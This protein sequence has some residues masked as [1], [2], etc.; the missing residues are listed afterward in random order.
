MTCL[1][2]ATVGGVLAL[3]DW[4]WSNH[5]IEDVYFTSPGFAFDPTGSPAVAYAVRTSSK[6]ISLFFATDDPVSPTGQPLA[7]MRQLVDS[8]SSIQ[9]IYLGFDG[10][11]NPGIAYGPGM[12]YAHHD[13]GSWVI[14]QID[15]SSVPSDLAFDATGLPA[16]VFDA[17]NGNAPDVRIARRTATGWAIEVVKARANAFSGAALA[18]DNAGSPV[19]VYNT[20]GAVYIARRDTTG[21]TTAVL[22]SGA[23]NFG[24]QPD[25]AFDRASDGNPLTANYNRPAIAYMSAPPAGASAPRSL[26][27]SRNDGVPSEVVDPSASRLASVAFDAQGQPAVSYIGAGGK[28]LRFAS[29]TSGA[30]QVSTIASV[31][32]GTSGSAMYPTLAFSPVDAEAGIAWM[33]TTAPA[34][35]MFSRGVPV[36]PLSER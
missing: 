5:V 28:D 35:L 36:L 33:D 9:S 6:R 26:L 22:E 31:A 1:L 24:L 30:W 34:R 29:R 23:S 15:R 3:E 18:F 16:I 4:Q 2:I 7:A 8:G 27:Y 25:I 17:G 10:N 19:V 11:G 32:A 12:R 20:G 13:G 14:E 21:W